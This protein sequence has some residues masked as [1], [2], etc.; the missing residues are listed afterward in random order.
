VKCK[1][2]FAKSSSKLED[3][4]NEWI[5]HHVIRIDHSH[6]TT[7][8]LDGEITNIG[9]VLFYTSLCLNCPVGKYPNAG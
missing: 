7:A 2:F 1:V 3:M 8:S 5:Q 6:L 4:V 9:F